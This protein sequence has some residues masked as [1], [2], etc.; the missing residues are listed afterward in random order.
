MHLI[1]NV[2]LTVLCL[3]QDGDRILLQNRVKHLEF[4]SD[5]NLDNADSLG[6]QIA[7]GFEETNRII[8]FRKSLNST[9]DIM[10]YQV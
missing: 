6:F 9:L 3:I 8:C 5:Y 7:V 4:A 10:Q 2:E 1:E